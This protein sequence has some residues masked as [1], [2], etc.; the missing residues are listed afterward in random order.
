MDPCKSNQQAQECHD[1]QTA[2]YRHFL[3]QGMT[4]ERASFLAGIPDPET[5][6]L[7]EEEN[8]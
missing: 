5:A 1:G 8:D 7:E 2:A 3:E 4:S 6:P